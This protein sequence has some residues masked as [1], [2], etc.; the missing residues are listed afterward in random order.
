MRARISH[1]QDREELRVPRISKDRP[2]RAFGRDRGHS[3]RAA[4]LLRE[5]TW[6]IHAIA[7]R[8]SEVWPNARRII[9]GADAVLD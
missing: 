2:W 5:I 7:P 3:L 1:G 4:R 6:R 8:Y 9:S